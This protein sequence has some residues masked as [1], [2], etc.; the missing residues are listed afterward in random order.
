MGTIL[1]IAFAAVIVLGGVWAFFTT[2]RVKRDGID[3]E[4]VVSC[5]KESVIENSDGTDDIRRT[6]YVQYRTLEGKTVEA[7]LS[8][9]KSDL[10]EGTRVLIKYLPNKTEYPVL[11]EILD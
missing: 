1:L 5:I 6:T 9:P 7:V 2:R 10:T 4:A 11:I 3:A 8:N